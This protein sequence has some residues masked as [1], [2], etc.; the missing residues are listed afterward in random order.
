MGFGLEYLDGNDG[1]VC[2]PIEAA[3]AFVVLPA[4]QFPF[5]KPICSATCMSYFWFPQVLD[6]NI[7]LIK[8]NLTMPIY[9]QAGV[10]ET[11]TPPLTALVRVS[12][13]RRGKLSPRGETSLKACRSLIVVYELWHISLHATL[14][15]VITYASVN[16]NCCPIQIRGPPL[17]GRY[18]QLSILV[19]EEISRV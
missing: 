3:L 18:C 16:A 5:K 9:V 13:S 6:D 14:I 15:R 11:G 4:F 7:H 12:C 2:H 10:N 1:K 17:N 8:M 19:R